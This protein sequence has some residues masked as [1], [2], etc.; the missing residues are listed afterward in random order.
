[1]MVLYPLCC[2]R[3]TALIVSVTVP[4][5][6]TFTSKALAIPLSIPC[7]I[8]CSFVTNK[9]SPTS[10]HL[11]P[12]VSDRF[13]QPS[14]SS[15]AMPSSMEAMGYCLTQLAQYFTSW[16]LLISF[17][18]LLWNTYFFFFASHNSVL[19]ASIAIII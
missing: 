7:C 12:T 5:W 9:S 14:Q 19:A 15:S 2:A 10:W 1:M 8:L 3:V 6:F 18:L 13:F 4:I 17:P 11:L 16:S